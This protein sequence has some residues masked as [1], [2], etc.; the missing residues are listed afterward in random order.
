MNKFKVDVPVKAIEHMTDEN[1]NSGDVVSP[2]MIGRIV[3][4]ESDG[5]VTVNFDNFGYW[6][7]LGKDLA[8]LE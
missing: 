3:R 5:W 1:G 6:D 2:G 4:V 7:C 8:P